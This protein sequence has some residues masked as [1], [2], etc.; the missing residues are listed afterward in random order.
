MKLCD[1]KSGHSWPPRLHLGL[2][3]KFLSYA[4]RNSLDMLF[5]LSYLVLVVCR[6]CCADVIRL[7]RAFELIIALSLGL[8]LLIIWYCINYVF[9]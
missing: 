3:M 6:M 8:S 5:E 1:S 4:S 7:R 2:C 9:L